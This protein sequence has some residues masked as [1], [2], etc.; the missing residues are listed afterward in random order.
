VIYFGCKLK[1][2]EKVNL[3]QSKDT[4]PRV[5]KSKTVPRIAG[6]PIATRVVVDNSILFQYLIKNFKN[7]LLT[8][9]KNRNNKVNKKY[10]GKG[11]VY[12]LSN[13]IR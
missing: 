6:L 4:K 13:T 2:V 11:R 3:E 10:W 9:G 5:L 7:S 12:F 8:Y 1:R